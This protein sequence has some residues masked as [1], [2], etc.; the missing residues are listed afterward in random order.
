[1]SYDSITVL[2]PIEA[3]QTNPGMFIGDVSD[4]THLFVEVFDNAIDEVKS[5][6]ASEID[7][8][9]KDVSFSIKDNGRGFPRHDKEGNDA[10]DS[11]LTKLFSGAKFRNQKEAYGTSRGLYGVGLSA[12]NALSASVEVQS[13]RKGDDNTRIRRFNYGKLIA[14][15]SSE[16]Q[17][18]GTSVSVHPSS[19]YFDSILIKKSAILSRIKMAA[20]LH[21]NVFIK[22]NEETISGYKLEELL[23]GPVDFGP[24]QVKVED[25]KGQSVWAIF[26]YE[27]SATGTMSTGSVNSAQVN[28]GT[29]ISRI[30][31]AILDSWSPYNDGLH[32]QDLAI[33]LR[34][35]V[36]CH[37]LDP[38]YTTQT[39]E[40]LKVKAQEFREIEEKITLEFKNWLKKN[41]KSRE[42]LLRKFREYRK[43]LNRIHTTDYLND[44]VRLGGESDSQSRMGSGDS[45]LLDCGSTSRDGTELFVVEGDSAYGSLLQVR[46]PNVHAIL[47]LR[48]K[49]MNVVDRPI[50]DILDN[51]EIRSLIN[52]IGA[53]AFQVQ[54][55]SSIRYSKIILMCDAD[56]DGQHILALLIGCLCYVV[57]QAVMGG[58]IY[59]LQAP[60]Y[61]TYEKRKFTPIYDPKWNGENLQRYK[62]LGEM[63]PDEIREI[64]VTRRRRLHR[65]QIDQNGIENVLNI[66]GTRE[67]KRQVLQQIGLL[68]L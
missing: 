63:N 4:P 34:L 65:I 62:G 52:G 16:S 8:E 10:I 9:M 64:S 31:K 25:E 50:R 18:Q 58:K 46:D 55:V 33:G 57:P 67:G 27:Q 53:G 47:P 35:F 12:V 2:D 45:K 29:H 54:Q 43:A 21:S 42:A 51:L 48:G 1:M 7:I 36:S 32:R 66:V 11:A 13:C 15:E 68:D 61:G 40:T 56:S 14:S 22:L 60:L 28:Y 5:G 59:Y 23:P 30:E 26:G 6:N 19:K 41:S 17:S 38:Q 20:T 24:I 49:S 3:I 39:K 37:I 44:V